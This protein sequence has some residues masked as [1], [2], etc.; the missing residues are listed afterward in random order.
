MKKLILIL[1]SLLVFSLFV[2]AQETT[3][4]TSTQ[5]STTTPSKA[6]PPEATSTPPKGKEADLVCMKNAVEKRENA[7]KTARETYF[8]KVM[9]AYEAR[10][11]AL[12]DA[13]TIQNNKERQKKIHEAWKNFRESVRSA[14]LEYK[15]EHNQIWKTFVQ[16]RKNCKANPTGENPGIDL[17]F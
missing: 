14:W 17:N 5:Q 13:W 7:L 16:E 2:L 6:T 11:T 12:L 8:N 3:T 1:I 15:K 4:P 9:Q 10:K